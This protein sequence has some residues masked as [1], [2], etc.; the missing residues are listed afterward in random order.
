MKC[1]KMCIVKRGNS[2]DNVALQIAHVVVRCHTR[3]LPQHDNGTSVK[4]LGQRWQVRETRQGA[5]GEGEAE[6]VGERGGRGGRGG[7]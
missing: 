1:G 6:R 4:Q 2:E 5:A 3:T 7:S